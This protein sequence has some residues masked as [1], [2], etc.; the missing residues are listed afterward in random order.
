MLCERCRQ[1]LDE[2]A[3]KRGDTLCTKCRQLVITIAAKLRQVAIR[4]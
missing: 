1:K 4:R 3:R 2:A